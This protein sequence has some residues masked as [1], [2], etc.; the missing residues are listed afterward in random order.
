MKSI[1]ELKNLNFE[2][3][4]LE[5]HDVFTKPEMNKL[6]VDFY[7]RI[8]LQAYKLSIKRT[9]SFKN[10]GEEVDPE[11]L[12]RLV[13]QINSKNKK[14]LDFAVHELRECPA[15]YAL[16]SNQFLKISSEIL[17]CPDSLLKIHIDGILINVPSNKQR[18]YRFHSEQHYYPYR[19]NFFNFWMPLI[20]NKT[21][22][23]G[24]MIVKHK[25]HVKNYKFNEY[26][27]FEK[28]EGYEAS[29]DNFFYQLEIPTAEIEEFESVM[30]DLEIGKGLFFSSNM[31][32]SSKINSSDEV[33]YALIIRVYDYRRDLTLSDKT[34][35]KSYQASEGGYPDIKPVLE[36]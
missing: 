21:E 2:N 12:D 24:A 7:N 19:R 30:T 36:D 33:S 26:S 16:I 31:P 3:D 20:R 34:G 22:N 28:V 9:F 35:I 10:Y 23:N 8:L 32:H 14:S 17:N 25:G 11:E 1:N 4:G 13:I 5:I 6:S 15:F 29:E 27:G 18:L